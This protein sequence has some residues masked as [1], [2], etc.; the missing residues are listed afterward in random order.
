MSIQRYRNDNPRSAEEIAN[1]IESELKII[2]SSAA[3]TEGTQN[4][5]FILSM[6]T[7]LAERQEVSL[8]ELYDAAYITDATD[9]ELTKRARGIGV[10][11]QDA[12]AATGVVEFSRGSPAST[13]R[14]APSGTQV[15]TGGDDAADFETTELA[16]IEGPSTEVDS[17]E[18]T[19]TSESY[20]T[21]TSFTIDVTY[22]DNID[23]SANIK[24]G[25][26]GY[27][28]TLDVVNATDSVT[29]ASFSTTNT[30]YTTK[31]PTSYDVSSLSGEKTIE[32]QL[33]ISDST[34]TVGYLD[35]STVD[36]GGETGAK[37]NVKCLDTGPIGNVGA[38]TIE[39]LLDSPSG[40]EDVTNPSPTGD[41]TFTLTDN[42]T[43]LL[44]GSAEE[45]DQELRQRALDSTAIGGA[46]TVHALELALENLIEVNSADVFSNRTDNT[47]DGVDPWHTEVRI[48]GG[49]IND[50]AQLLYEALPLGT[51]KTLQ[52]GANGTKETTTLSASDLLGDITIPITRPTET[53]LEIEIDVVHDASYAGTA[54]AKDA[55]VRYVGG[56]T[57]DS[58]TLT[59]LGQG[60]NVLVNEIEN[61]VEDEPGVDYADVTL[62][63]S[64]GDGNDDT[65]TDTDG[66]PIYSVGDSEVPI[67]NAS[68]IT[69]SETQ[70]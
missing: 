17:T 28:T 34:A 9:E 60:E 31:G 26:A 16:I 15:S 49:N 30:S 19:T 70:R 63:D 61:T 13:N 22:R 33:K 29:I 50:I 42:S 64:D 32:F 2:N 59:G 45:E 21:K 62:L 12:T 41:P 38:N 69:V 53:T 58:S 39:T 55:I 40:I 56:T 1:A 20:V 47:V 48:Y 67:A 57:T 23:V 66:V 5:A 37:A 52:G 43:P 27:T 44:N 36:K 18:Y 24:T 8:N 6:A 3:T 14:T 25:N 65:T 54:A 35:E 10:I 4:Y 46:G 11:R 51:L 68:D 7:T